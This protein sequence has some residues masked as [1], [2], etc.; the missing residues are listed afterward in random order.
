MSSC[1]K[2][3]CTF[4]AHVPVIV[5]LYKER[6][7]IAPNLY[8][9]HR[10]IL[11]E[12]FVS[13]SG[14]FGRGLKGSLLA[15]GIEPAKNYFIK[16]T[17]YYERKRKAGRWPWLDQMLFA[18]LLFSFF[19]TANAQT[20]SGTVS[21]ETGKKLSSVSVTVKGTTTGATTDASGQYRINAGGNATL[22]FSSI[23]Y[24]TMDVTVAD[25][26]VVD[27]TLST[28]AQSLDAVVITALG[29][30]KQARGL[31]Y[32]A[33]NV[34]SEELTINRTP[35]VMNALQ[36]RW[37]VSTYLH[38]VQDPEEHLRSASGDSHQLAVKIIRSS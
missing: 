19:T 32:A 27:V 3:S 25:R 33:T 4:N 26:S 14:Y 20:I 21:D 34:K 28:N 9:I 16:T 10:R 18:F 13:E 36:G 24:S 15:N 7:F 30:S 6:E 29:I 8:K 38:W 1:A 35:N 11:L 17:C 5:N 22:V 31:G 23:G 2:T 37:R 12:V